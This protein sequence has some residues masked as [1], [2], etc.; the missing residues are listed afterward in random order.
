MSFWKRRKQAPSLA[1]AGRVQK[2]KK[3]IKRSPPVAMEV[4][5]LALE[6]LDS[7]LSAIE[8][9]EWV[10]D[11]RRRIAWLDEYFVWK[12]TSVEFCCPVPRRALR[13]EQQKSWFLDRLR[14]HVLM[15]REGPFCEW[16]TEGLSADARNGSRAP[17]SCHTSPTTRPTSP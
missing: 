12:E 4:K 8:V 9:G 16:I 13:F 10:G 17:R 14:G 6:A 2:P 1:D 5:I 7:G 3:T 15:V 11:L